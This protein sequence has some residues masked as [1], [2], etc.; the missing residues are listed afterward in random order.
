MRRPIDYFPMQ[1]W[2]LDQVVALAPDSASASAGQALANA[3]KWASIG[4]SDRA[5]WGLCQGSGKDPYQARI[6]LSE[7]AFKC[8]CPSRKFPCK[9]GLGLLLHFAKDA[10]AFKEQPEPGWV[11]EWIAGRSE[12][13]EKKAEK[14]KATAEKPVDV[15]AQAKRAAKRESR[16]EDGIA[17]C[18]VWLED[19]VRRGLA[20]AQTESG[21]EFERMAARMVDA[22]APGLASQIRRVPEV[23]A[24]GAG[25]DVRTLDHLGRI[26]LLLR[27][28]ER[29]KELPD[30]LACDVRTALGWNQSKEDVLAE[31]GVLDRWVS[32]GQVVE[33]EDRLRSRRTWL[34]GRTTRRRALLLD[35]AAGLSPLPPGIVAATEFEG[36]VA[37]YPGRLPLRALV[38]TSGESESISSDVED[39][40]DGT[41]EDALRGYSAALALNPWLSRWPLV[42][43]GVR[44]AQDRDQWVLVDSQDQGLPLRPSFN[45]GVQIWRLLSASGE[46]TSARSSF[47]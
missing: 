7:P 16:V 13:A 45:A 43:R 28:G 12:R 42:L 33:E 6:D 14:T 18:R 29:V 3:K 41:V 5:I 31:A 37:F 35:F 10:A 30:D 20:S 47:S 15:E 36:E 26:H 17:S 39:A 34:I 11:A 9:H 19:W 24:S 27:A 32:L 2:T 25:W 1:S 22:Q 38:K 40:A 46:S 4:R 8:S 44:L 21:A 23:I